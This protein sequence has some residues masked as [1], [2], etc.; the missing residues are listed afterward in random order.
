MDKVKRSKITSISHKPTSETH[1]THK[2]QEQLQS[3]TEATF[4]YSVN[5]NSSESDEPIKHGRRTNISLLILLC[6][7]FFSLNYGDMSYIK[8]CQTNSFRLQLWA[9]MSQMRHF[10]PN[11]TEKGFTPDDLRARG[12]AFWE[13]PGLESLR[14]GSYFHNVHT[15]ARTHTHTQTHTHK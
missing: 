10:W 15:R 7:D 3:E 9:W 11:K 4:I 8:T 14:Y 13:G 5:I 1:I 12:L 6:K 2:L